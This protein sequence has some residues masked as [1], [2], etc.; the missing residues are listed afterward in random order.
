MTK[1]RT[2]G[3]TPSKTFQT[4]VHCDEE[5]RPDKQKDN[6]NDQDNDSNT[7]NLRDI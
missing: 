6:D 3:K 1:T 7:D 2:F 5:T 4:F